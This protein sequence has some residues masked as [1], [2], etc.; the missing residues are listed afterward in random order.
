M[1]AQEIAQHVFAQL[2]DNDGPRE[3]A[4]YVAVPGDG[5]VRWLLPAH[6]KALDEVLASWTPY[7]T[8]S[9]IAWATVRAASIMGAITGL[10]GVA[11]LDVERAQGVDWRS[12]G[13]RWDGAPIPV[14]YVGTPGPR[15][16]A[17]V[18]LVESGSG[19]CRAV[20]KVPLTNDAKTASLHEAEVLAALEE[21]R[22]ES[23]PRLLHVDRTRGLLT[24][25]FLEGRP[26]S[27]KLDEE[28]WRLLRSLLLPA[29]TT[30]LRVHAERWELEA[31]GLR[32]PE[33]VET[34]LSDLADNEPVPACWQHG[35]FAPWNIR[36]MADGQLVL[37]D[38]EEARRDGL[39]LCDAFHF[40]HMQDL[41]FGKSPQLH[42][43]DIDGAVG[44]SWVSARMTGKLEMAY[45]VGAYVRCFKR[46]NDERARFLE[47]TL[48]MLQRRAA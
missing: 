17:V 20:V 5:E 35:D 39:P 21:E 40:L 33:C 7:R 45:L 36:R 12:L 8:T 42:A 46:G 38:W 43:G 9:R 22:H 18:H 32:L 37:L 31:T 2:G 47:G 3:P 26:G 19:K 16:R 4:Q 6:V 10:P 11:V 29:Q 28:H 14:I 48:A 1:V 41:L 25:T 44:E 34:A 15:R 27:R 23:A 13:W 24:Q 30:S